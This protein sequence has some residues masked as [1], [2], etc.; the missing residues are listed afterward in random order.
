MR[1]ALFYSIAACTLIGI[2]LGV[3]VI[4]H[5]FSPLS[6]PKSICPHVLAVR[7]QVAPH[8]DMALTIFALVFMD[9]FNTIGTLIGAA[10][11]TEMMDAEGT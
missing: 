6:M 2:P 8:P 11:N 5:G 10:A 1:G 4:P 7:L 3:T 9:I